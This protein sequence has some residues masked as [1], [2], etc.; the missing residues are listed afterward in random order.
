MPF[1]SS[2]EANNAYFMSGEATKMH[3]SL[4]SGKTTNEVYF[5]HFTR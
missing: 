2:S 3:I 4:M 1:V 5:S